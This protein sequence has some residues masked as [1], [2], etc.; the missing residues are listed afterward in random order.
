MTLHSTIPLLAQGMKSAAANGATLLTAWTGIP[1]PLLAGLLA[2]ESFD[3][4]TLDMQ[5]GAQ[6]IASVTLG[7]GMVS[8]AGKPTIVRIPVGQFPIASRV[9]DLGASAVIAPMIN[10]KADAEAFASFV[11][12]P[13]MGDRSWG[14]AV[15]MSM[16]PG[17]TGPDYL[18]SGNGMHLSLAMIE[19]REALA[20]LDDILAVP[21]IDAVFVG[22]SDLSI[23]LTRGA[24]VDPTRKDVADALAHVAARAKAHGK[25][26]TCFAP[27]PEDVPHLA[28]AGYSLMAISTDFM[29]LRAGARASLTAAGRAS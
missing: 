13:P 10:S 6:D 2:R 18:K 12:F 17:M 15:T 1:D 3:T 5:H 27:R 22:P 23:A 24:E 14:P 26:A 19:T 25:L 4:V 11:K 28:K 29:Q 8:A 21:G 16:L 7:I 9:L 20:A